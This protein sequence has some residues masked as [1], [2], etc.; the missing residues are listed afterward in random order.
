MGTKPDWEV[1]SKMLLSSQQQFVR[2][3]KNGV[4][5]FQ[6]LP[7][8]T[9]YSR[10][11]TKQGPEHISR[12]S[13]AVAFFCKMSIEPDKCTGRWVQTKCGQLIW[14]IFVKFVLHLI[15]IACQEN[16]PFLKWPAIIKFSY[17]P[18]LTIVLWRRSL[19]H[20]IFDE[21]RNANRPMNLIVCRTESKESVRKIFAQIFIK[22]ALVDF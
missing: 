5:D 21:K 22:W 20:W 18:I 1:S 3:K 2:L 16:N 11:F 4:D 12:C 8:W 19:S 9:Q 17:Q 13:A 14:I 10:Q 6:T 7:T 15:I